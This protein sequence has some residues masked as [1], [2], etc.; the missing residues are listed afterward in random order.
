[1]IQQLFNIFLNTNPSVVTYE[2]VPYDGNMAP[3]H[4]VKSFKESIPDNIVDDI[5]NY[6]N[7]IVN[8]RLKNITGCTPT[9]YTDEYIYKDIIHP[10]HT[11]KEYDILNHEINFQLEKKW[12]KYAQHNHNIFEKDLYEYV[13]YPCGLESFAE[14]IGIELIQDEK[15]DAYGTGI[16][17]VENDEFVIFST[18]DNGSDVNRNV[19]TTLCCY[20]I[21]TYQF[22]L[23]DIMYEDGEFYLTEIQKTEMP[24]ELRHMHI[25]NLSGKRSFRWNVKEKIVKFRSTKEFREVVAEKLNKEVD[26]DSYKSVVTF[27]LE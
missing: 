6:R 7:K 2:C 9:E 18:Y 23:A 15:Y 25:K 20:N 24:E 10:T 14:N 3:I 12:I 21:E 16:Y 19:V 27:K 17:K 4:S 22:E 11:A 13:I 5:I 8:T 1:M 26:I